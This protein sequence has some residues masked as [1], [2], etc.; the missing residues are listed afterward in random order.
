[1]KNKISFIVKTYETRDE[2]LLA[3]VY[4]HDEYLINVKKADFQTLLENRKE[5]LKR[6]NKNSVYSLKKRVEAYLH[7]LIKTFLEAKSEKKDI[8]KEE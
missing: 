1:M 6:L 8:E 5:L 7:N 2:Y 3:I 4:M